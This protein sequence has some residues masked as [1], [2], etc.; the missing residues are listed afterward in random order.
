MKKLFSIILISSF[1]YAH[2]FIKSQNVVIDIEKNIMWQDDIEAVSSPTGWTM[3]KEQ[4]AELT[5]NG[6]SDWRLPSIKQLQTIVDVSRANPAINE[7]FKFVE[8]SS[9]WSR[10]PDLTNKGIA[11]YVGFKTGATFKDSKD[12]DCY[13][14]CVRSRFKK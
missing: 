2:N 14:R 5:L 10:S 9:Y 6:Y 13:I 12:Y 3:A 7:E 8:P 4:C 11:W 1:L